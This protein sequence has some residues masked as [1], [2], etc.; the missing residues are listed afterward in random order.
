MAELGTGLGNRRVVTGLD[1]DGKSAVV[2]DGPIPRF[3]AV[4]AALAWRTKTTPADNSGN[5]DTVAPYE[6][7]MLHTPGSNFSICEFAPNSPEH[8]HATDTIDYLVIL[9]GKVT[10]VL[11]DGEADLGPG[12]FVVDRGVLHGWRNPHGERCIAAVVNLP[13]HR[14]G[15]GRTI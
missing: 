1:A 6:I 9:S 4:S 5:A 14:V 7:S 10:L 12:D 2:I 8:M 15:K 13:A 11:E 3:N